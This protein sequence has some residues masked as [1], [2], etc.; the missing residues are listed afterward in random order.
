MVHM[1][2]FKIKKN[3]HTNFSVSELFPGVISG[4]E[5]VVCDSKGPVFG[6]KSL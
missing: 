3:K 5:V 1:Y 6:S 4:A 2:E